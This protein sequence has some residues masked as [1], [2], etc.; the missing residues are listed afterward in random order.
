MTTL[1]FRFP[2]RSYLTLNK[3]ISLHH[4]YFYHFD[5][6]CF[7]YIPMNFILRI[8][9][10]FSER[11]HRFH[12]AAKG[13]HGKKVKSFPKVEFQKELVKWRVH[14]NRYT[15]SHH[16]YSEDIY[17]EIKC[18]VLFHFLIYDFGQLL[19]LCLTL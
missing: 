7:F 13:Y 6:R 1:K 3:H 4:K 11:I 15:A 17:G 10:Q 2:A 14:W 12:Q 5:N 18:W 9:K 8:L 19:I 16:Y